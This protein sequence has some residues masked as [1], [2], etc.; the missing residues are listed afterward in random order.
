M[1]LGHLRSKR[2]S[3]QQERVRKCLARVDPRNVRIRLATTVSQRAYSV[4]VSNSLWHLDSHH[5]LISWEFVIHGAID[6][7]SRF[8]TF[9]HCST[10]NTCVHVNVVPRST[11][12]T[13]AGTEN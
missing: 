1:V 6:G 5:S 3:I 4:A 7:F 8:V 2:L 13:N 10:N 12:N 11:M 9:L